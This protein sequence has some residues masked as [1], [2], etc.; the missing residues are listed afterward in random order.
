MRG[1]EN[2]TEIASIIEKTLAININL[3]DAFSKVSSDDEIVLGR[4][5]DKANAL[6]TTLIVDNKTG[7]NDIKT[8]LND[9]KFGINNMTTIMLEHN[10]RLEAILEKIS[11]R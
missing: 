8:G 11:R 1:A 7:F 4:K 5:F 6:L 2:G 9:V 10:T 3:P